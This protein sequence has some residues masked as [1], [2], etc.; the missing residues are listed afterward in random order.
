MMTGRER[1]RAWLERSKLTQ[2]AAAEVL[3]MHEV[4]LSQI[5]GGVRVPGLDNAVK[6][7]DLTGIAVRSW[8]QTEVSDGR[9]TASAGIG[10]RS[11]AKR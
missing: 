6:I 5:L 3:G 10:N 7:E 1:L 2:R 4:Y 9:P 8:Q 11:K